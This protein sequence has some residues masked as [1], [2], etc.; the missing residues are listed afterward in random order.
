MHGSMRV[1]GTYSWKNGGA[2]KTMIERV[3]ERFDI[4]PERLAADTAYGARFR[5]AGVF[6]RRTVGLVA[7]VLSLFIVSLSLGGTPPAGGS[8]VSTLPRM[9][10]KPSLP[11]PIKTTFEFVDC[12]S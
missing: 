3:E 7:V 10:G 9:T 8:G 6:S 4:K 11:L 1:S 5:G 2:A 12:E